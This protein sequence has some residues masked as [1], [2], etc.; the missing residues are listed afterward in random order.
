[1]FWFTDAALRS[2]DTFSEKITRHYAGNDAII[3]YSYVFLLEAQ[4]LLPI[5]LKT[6]NFQVN[7]LCLEHLIKVKH[8]IRTSCIFMN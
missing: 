7:L 6:K 3:H 8:L 1:M 5:C 2:L 4:E